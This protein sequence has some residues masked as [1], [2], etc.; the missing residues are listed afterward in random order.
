MRSI[1]GVADEEMT[2][3]KVYRILGCQDDRWDWHSAFTEQHQKVWF[4]G[5]KDD[6]N[7]QIGRGHSLQGD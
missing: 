7:Y 2:G 4:G 6:M 5:G 3:N 1:C